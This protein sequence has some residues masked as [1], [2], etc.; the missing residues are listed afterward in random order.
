MPALGVIALL[1]WLTSH[2][3]GRFLN[4]APTALQATAHISTVP[5]GL[6]LY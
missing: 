1:I 4:S 2:Y 6:S 3:G 5:N